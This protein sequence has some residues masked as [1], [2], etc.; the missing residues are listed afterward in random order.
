MATA[1][2]TRGS[3][4]VDEALK[5]HATEVLEAVGDERLAGLSLVTSTGRSFSAGADIV[6]LIGHILERIAQGG[7]LSVHT[8]P[9]MLTTSAAADLLGVSRTSVMKF[10]RS[11]EL[12]SEKTGTHHRL[13]HSD[14]MKFKAK[15]EVA[16][17]AAIDELL[18]LEGTGK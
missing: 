14:V 4:V 17:S 18:D 15:R 8:L 10:I 16:R 3:L 7:E 5:A 12:K 13:R 1:L 2:L 6:E 11:G 9:E